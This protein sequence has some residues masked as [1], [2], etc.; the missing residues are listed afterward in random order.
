MT[1]DRKE[2]KNEKMARIVHRVFFN[3]MLLTEFQQIH[4]E[5]EDTDMFPNKNR[6]NI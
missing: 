6:G 2:M 4:V 3:N 1:R 5:A